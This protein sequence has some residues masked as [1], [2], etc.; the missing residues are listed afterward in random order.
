MKNERKTKR[1]WKRVNKL[2][3]QKDG[4][5]V[6]EEKSKVTEG[7]VCVKLQSTNTMDVTTK[8]KKDYFKYLKI[9]KGSH[10]I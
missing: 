2:E 8:C 10:F 5:V 4:K 7:K 1:L 9:S 3:L 6:T